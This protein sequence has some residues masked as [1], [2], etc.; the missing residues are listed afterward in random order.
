MQFPAKPPLLAVSIH[1]LRHEGSQNVLGWRRCTAQRSLGWSRHWAVFAELKGF[2]QR[3]R[4][5]GRRRWAG[6]SSIVEYVKVRHRIDPS[7]WILRKLLPH[8]IRKIL[9]ARAWIHVVAKWERYQF[10]REVYR[11]E[12]LLHIT[13]TCQIISESR[14]PRYCFPRF[15]SVWPAPEVVDGIFEVCPS[16]TKFCPSVDNPVA[17]GFSLWWQFFDI[18]K[19]FCPLVR[20]GPKPIFDYGCYLSTL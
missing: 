3:V 5:R 11:I 2:L 15:V 7:W 12:T 14:H 13:V 9:V 19:Q 16:A 1:K 18:S 8:F 17:L 20:L 10:Y 6:S 4:T